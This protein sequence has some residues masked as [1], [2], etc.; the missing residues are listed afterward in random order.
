MVAGSLHLGE[1]SLSGLAASG[2]SALTAAELRAV[3]ALWGAQK[4]ERVARFGG[5][6]MRPSIA[7]GQAVVVRWGEQPRL[8]EVAVFQRGD[9]LTVHR[10]VAEHQG[11]LLTWG[12]ANVIPDDP[13]DASKQVLGVVVALERDGA[14]LPVPPAAPRWWK[15]TLLHFLLPASERVP[16][17]F[18]ARAVR[19]RLVTGALLGRFEPLLHRVRT[20]VAS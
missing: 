13:V 2:E 3:G 9:A 17:R 18:G 1:G 5:T 12:D 11:F 16:G 20:R 10:V 14:R 4:R 15:R 19:L 6:S 8:G 7:P